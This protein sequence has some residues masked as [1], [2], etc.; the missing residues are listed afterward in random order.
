MK[1][2][3]ADGGIGRRTDM[4]WENEERVNPSLDEMLLSPVTIEGCLP[5]HVAC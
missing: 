2:L 3:M 5:F 1:L 4:L